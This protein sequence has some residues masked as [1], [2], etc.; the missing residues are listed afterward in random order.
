MHSNQKDRGWIDKYSS[1][2]GLHFFCNRLFIGAKIMQ[3]RD[4]QNT[5]FI[6]SMADAFKF[7]AVQEQ[8][9]DL[10]LLLGGGVFTHQSLKMG[11]Q[12]IL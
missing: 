7:S 6:V 10:K 9:L 8:D 5:C 4:Q 3:E 1:Y 11:D 12:K 2:S